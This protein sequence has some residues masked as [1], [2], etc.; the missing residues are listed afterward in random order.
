MDSKY[1]VFLSVFSVLM[2][3]THGSTINRNVMDNIQTGIN[4][5]GKMFGKSK[6]SE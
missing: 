3:T 6:R 5:A 2:V 4:L 1:L